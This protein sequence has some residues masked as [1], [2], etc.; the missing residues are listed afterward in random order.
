[1]PLSAG[2]DVPP[3]L[4][5][6]ARVNVL[7]VFHGDLAS[8]AFGAIRGSEGRRVGGA[9][10]KHVV[11]S[12]GVPHTEI[13]RLEVN[14]REVSFGH[15]LRDGDRIEV[16]PPVPPVDLS[17]STLLRPALLDGIRFVA[18]VNVGKLAVLL[19]MA[20]FDTVYSSRLQDVDLADIAQCEG[21]VLLTRDR[22]LLRRKNV[23]HGRLVRAIHP[24]AQLSEVLRLFGLRGRVAPFSRCLRCNERL[25][26][27]AKD[28]VVHRLKPLTRLHYDAFSACRRCDR[29]Y[30]AGSHKAD[31]EQ[32]LRSCLAGA[33]G[34]RS[35]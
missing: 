18:D 33:E 10:V 24:E 3:A 2:K 16:Y 32:A 19:R 21:R 23:A 11:E 26:P 5:K 7:L 6:S 29:I 9:S 15:I 35:R 12:A 1:M 17:V 25:V 27:V 14:R 13:H 34:G 4:T 31:M 30:W 20:G 28:S 8:L 22:A